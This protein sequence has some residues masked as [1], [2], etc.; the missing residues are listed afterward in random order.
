MQAECDA[1]RHHAE[2]AAARSVNLQR[3]KQTHRIRQLFALD[4]EEGE[5][6]LEHD[7]GYAA[8]TDVGGGSRG[9]Q[10]QPSGSHA[11]RRLQFEQRSQ[12]AT[13]KAVQYCTLLA[14]PLAALE[15]KL[16]EE[17]FATLQQHVV[18]YSRNPI[19]PGCAHPPGS[20]S[21]SKWRPVLIRSIA[22]SGLIEI[23]IFRCARP[24]WRAWAGIVLVLVPCGWLDCP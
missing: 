12:V 2:V 13:K 11:E 9:Q 3:S 16:M 23:P 22:G 18:T 14:E 4:E 8:D 17:P 20:I 5:L 21:I 6:H 1:A 19:H 15:R 7:D 24:P 10:R